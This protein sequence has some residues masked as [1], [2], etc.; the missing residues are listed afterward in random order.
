MKGIH[1]ALA[2]TELTHNLVG[3]LVQSLPKEELLLIPENFM[4]LGDMT[5]WS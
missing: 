2:P 1:K 3:G 4:M 5:E